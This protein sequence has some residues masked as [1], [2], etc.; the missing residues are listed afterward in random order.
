MNSTR[1]PRP[2]TLMIIVTGV[3]WLRAPASGRCT[4]RSLALAATL[5][6]SG[7]PPWKKFPSKNKIARPVP[8][9]ALFS[10]DALRAEEIH[11]VLADATAL[12]L[13]RDARRPRAAPLVA[14]STAGAGAVAGS[15][16]PADDPEQQNRQQ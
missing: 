7:T 6:F 5:V 9:A 10:R 2:A 1:C 15:L 4:F 12:L 8:R 13:H 14:L 16:R 3:S 11:F